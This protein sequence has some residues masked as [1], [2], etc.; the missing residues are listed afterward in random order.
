MTAGLVTTP[1]TPDR[2]DDLETLFG[3]SGAYCGCWCMYWRAPRRMFEDK[4]LRKTLRERFR[5]RVMAGPPPGL[6]AIDAGE[7]VGWVQVGPRADVPNWNGARRLSAPGDPADA[8]DPDV[9]GLSCFVVARPRRRQG[10]SAAL[11]AGAV[12]WARTNGA[13]A[14]DA[15]PVDAGGAAK[16]P[17]SVYHGL[18]STFRRAGFKEIARRRADRPLMRLELRR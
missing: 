5:A 8:E 15:C 12:D 13:R 17:V 18:A 1:L 10:A 11:L 3:P 14:L 4:A 2:W 16:P 7:P 9:W 6:L